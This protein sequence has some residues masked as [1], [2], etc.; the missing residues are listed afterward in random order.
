MGP[1]AGAE[2]DLKWTFICRPGKNLHGTNPGTPRSPGRHVPEG[3]GGAAPGTGP[4]LFLE[5]QDFRV[6]TAHASR[7]VRQPARAWQGGGK[8]TGPGTPQRRNNPG[9][10]RRKNEPGH[11]RP[12]VSHDRLRTGREAACQQEEKLNTPHRQPGP[13]VRDE[14]PTRGD[15]PRGALRNR[16]APPRPHHRTSSR[17]PTPCRGASPPA[18]SCRRASKDSSTEPREPLRPGLH[19]TSRQPRV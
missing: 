2:K 3:A 13:V 7:A 10:G 16:S 19:R 12:G 8:K 9:A 5:G 11:C 4:A 1:P 18:P 17:S 15:G 6:R 14:A